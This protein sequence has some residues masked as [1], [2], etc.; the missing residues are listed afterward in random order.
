MPALTAR[1][2]AATDAAILDAIRR[3]PD[4]TRI[5][6]ARE[7]GVTPAT[8]TNSVKRLLADGLVVESG[9]A[10][11]TGGKPAS[12]LRVSTTSRWAIG[13]TVESDRIALVAMGIGG[14]L[15]GRVMLPLIA[16]E[17]PVRTGE[18]LEAA[19]A[20][21]GAF[22][23]SER[24]A[25][26]GVGLT[27]LRPRS[28]GIEE[29][30]AHVEELT[31]Q[32]V[33]RG[34]AAVCAGLGS[35][36]VGEQDGGEPCLTVHLGPT[37]GVALLLDGRP[38]LPWGESPG[39]LPVPEAGCTADVERALA[40]GLGRHIDLDAVEERVITAHARL[41]EAAAH[42]DA[43]ASA[44]VVAGAER[45]A[46]AVGALIEPLGVAQ[47]VLSGTSVAMAPR[48]YLEAMTAHL[49]AGTRL[50]VSTVQPHPCAV[51]AA[52]LALARRG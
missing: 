14:A 39:I 50:R 9:R 41:T 51:G 42:G 25:F 27:D 6:I 3:V 45:I 26:Q 46:H 13:C 40:A 47:V 30:A 15:R 10:R 43:E 1:S 35:D 17:E 21:L 4:T 48:L 49:P 22:D 2:G 52:A 34:T 16:D 36:W 18:R 37:V 12:L 29:L 32:R 23:R 7:L 44:V 19:L 31:G 5:A 38:L 8:V 20:A 28:E 33:V 24:A 11:S